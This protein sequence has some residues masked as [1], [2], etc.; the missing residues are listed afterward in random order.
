MLALQRFSAVAVFVWLSLPVHAA[1]IRVPQDQ[2]TIKAAVAAANAGDVVLIACGN[3]VEN[4]IVVTV[5][6]QLKSETGDPSCVSVDASG[7]IAFHAFGSGSSITLDGIRV[8]RGYRGLSSSVATTIRSCVFET[9]GAAPAGY[10]YADG[11]A[12]SVSGVTDVYDSEFRWNF[13]ANGGAVITGPN[14]AFYRC[15]F[16]HNFAL[17]NGGA[18][19]SSSLNTRLVDC[20]FFRNQS[21]G[22]GFGGA[23]Y[24]ASNA[25]VSGCTFIEN[26]AG[27]EAGA[28]MYLTGTAQVVNTLIAVNYGGGAVRCSGSPTFSCCDIYGNAYG[29]WV[30]CIAGQLGVN[31]NFSADPLFCDLAARVLTLDA[32]SPCL[33]GNHPAGSACGQI[34][35]FGMGCTVVSAGHGL[36][37][38]P[39][40]RVKSLYR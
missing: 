6:I 7:G 1:T 2:P 37:S 39:W 23:L 30:S 31:G 36:T 10:G 20:L 17:E 13:A 26:A 40:G 15:L 28:A 35:R 32:E 3:Y 38:A 22:G 24:A 33:P 4:G 16:A 12:I 25:F 14:A 11:G 9:L 27:F 29:D 18:I 19:A 5:P 8:Y 21:L 34:G